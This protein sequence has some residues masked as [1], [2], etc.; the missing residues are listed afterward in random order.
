M[1]LS[2]TTRRASFD[3]SDKHN[4]AKVKRGCDNSVSH[5]RG[6]HCLQGK[7]WKCVLRGLAEL[8]DTDV[9]A[10]SAHVH[11]AT[12]ILITTSHVGLVS[13]GVGKRDF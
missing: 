9:T 2:E 13:E 4:P 11:A 10:A 3:E 1:R 5:P 8:V 12:P 7:Q 6:V